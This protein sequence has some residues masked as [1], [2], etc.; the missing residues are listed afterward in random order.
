[1]TERRT[2]DERPISAVVFDMDGVL[3]NSEVH[4]KTIESEFLRGLIPSWGSK[5]QEGIWGMSA[6]DVHRLLVERYGLQ[7]SRSDFLAFY[8]GLADTIYGRK[9]ELLPGVLEVL[10]DLARSGLPLGLAS[11]SPHAWIS[12]VLRRHELASFFKAVVSSDDLDGRGKPAPDIYLLTAQRLGIPPSEILAIED[13]PKGIRSA[14]DAG[15][16]CAGLR[17]G[18]NDSADL[19][20]ADFLIQSFERID[21][22]KLL[23]RAA[24]ARQ[25]Q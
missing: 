17:N 14:L 18:F 23:S 21:S 3:V 7:Q 2:N 22:G 20:T 24:A 15:M 5:D 6:Y 1:M 11:S 9:A 12:I 10:K 8:S 13:S 16:I 25:R 4:W 19:G